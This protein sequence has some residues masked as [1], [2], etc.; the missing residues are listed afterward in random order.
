VYSHRSL[1]I[2]LGS[3]FVLFS[4]QTQA[5]A[6]VVVPT[7]VIP[8]DTIQPILPEGSVNRSHQANNLSTKVSAANI[9]P[10]ETLLTSYVQ[11]AYQP[12]LPPINPILPAA[13]EEVRLVLKLGK[14]RVYVYQGNQLKK[15]YPVAIGRKGWETPTGRFEVLSMLQNPGWTHPFTRQVVPPGPNNPLGERWIAFWT[16]GKQAIGFHGT[17]ERGSIGKAASHGCVRMY[18][19]DIRELYNLVTPGTSITVES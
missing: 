4:A 10:P 7:E 19:E 17:P 2:C 5:D 6:D 11:T 14:R 16:N 1:Q 18:N 12:K 9:A 8:P 13:V 3:A 15:S